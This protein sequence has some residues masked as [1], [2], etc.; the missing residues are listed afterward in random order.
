MAC[1]YGNKG[2]AEEAKQLPLP[3]V[4]TCLRAPADVHR[5]DGY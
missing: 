4:K 1:L 2:G 3:D 5:V